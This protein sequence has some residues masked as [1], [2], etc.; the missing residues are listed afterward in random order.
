MCYV[1][2]LRS[3][4]HIHAHVRERGREISSYEKAWK[5]LK[6]I[7]INERRHSENTAYY[8][9]S[10][11]DMVEK[12]NLKTARSVITRG[13]EWGNCAKLEYKVFSGQ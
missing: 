9:I 6:S 4:T 13:L 11:T 12:V 10:T 8:I 5:K 2:T 7:P 3:Y 1:L